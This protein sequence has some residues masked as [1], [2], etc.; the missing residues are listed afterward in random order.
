MQSKTQILDKR[1][2]FFTSGASYITR[3]GGALIA[4]VGSMGTITNKWTIGTWIKRQKFFSALD[5]IFNLRN[6]ISNQ[7][8][9]IGF[10]NWIIGNT[11]ALSVHNASGGAQ[12]R[13][14]I[15][16]LNPYDLNSDWEFF[17]FTY[18]Y[19]GGTVLQNFYYNNTL[20]DESVGSGIGDPYL[21][22]TTVN[23]PEQTGIDKHIGIG[24]FWTNDPPGF[25]GHFYNWAM[26]DRVL[27]AAEVSV[28]YNGGAGWEPDYRRNYLQYSN[29]G[30]NFYYNFD[31]EAN[32]GENLGSVNRDLADDEQGLATYTVDDLPGNNDPTVYV[33]DDMSFML[34][35]GA[36]VNAHTVDGPLL[37][38]IYPSDINQ[39]SFSAWIKQS[40]ITPTNFDSILGSSTN[41]SSWSDGFG[42]YWSSGTQLTFWV[43]NWNTASTSIAGGNLGAD[44]WYHVVGVYDGS[45]S[46]MTLYVNNVIV[47]QE[48]G[49]S[50]DLLRTGTQNF[51]LGKTGN[52]NFAAGNHNSGFYSEVA[53]FDRPLTSTEINSLYNGGVP[54]SPGSMSGLRLW[55]RM[56]ESLGDEDFENATE[57]VNDQSGN[58]FDGT[59]TIGATSTGDGADDLR[60]VED[61]PT[62]QSRS[63]EFVASSDY[64]ETKSISP[65]LGLHGGD[66]TAA[67]WF[68]PTS[69]P[70]ASDEAVIFE[71]TDPSDESVFQMYIDDVSDLHIKLWDN[72]GTLFKHFQGTVIDDD[73]WNYVAFVFTDSGDILT[74]YAGFDI[75]GGV[76]DVTASMTKTVDNAGTMSNEG[77]QTIRF[78]NNAAHDTNFPGLIYSLS[79][80]DDDLTEAELDELFLMRS[81]RSPVSGNYGAYTSD[82]N[83][84]YQFDWRDTYLIGDN[85]AQRTAPTI[86]TSVGGVWPPSNTD[87]PVR[88]STS[89][90]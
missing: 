67:C 22:H 12:N 58:G 1:T 34:N 76:A 26:W 56:E 68:K 78:G 64:M 42:L 72:A 6:N 21:V 69:T 13:F 83:L 73:G 30:L 55:W 43:N 49:L 77:P 7:Q 8:G 59:P 90:G 14:E 87:I 35:I 27:S 3:E 19:N 53:L 40:D 57:V 71:T 47:A 36:S 18:D 80:W 89:G 37:S 46:L 79:L 31:N 33:L 50:A 86:D 88:F 65:Y 5:S 48:T 32:R 24:N 15:R 84:E 66:W 11:L 28:L 74:V 9:N 63:A 17:V 62:F 38:T 75:S 85:R 4:D 60:L 29:E 81:N 54:G 2:G 41:Y 25:G 20:L 16:D 51:Y 39:L 45:N 70:G 44:T 10:A 52:L 61:R 23:D 82:F